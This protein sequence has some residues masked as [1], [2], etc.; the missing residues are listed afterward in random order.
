MK[1]G[2]ILEC[3]VLHRAEAG[4]LVRSGTLIGQISP[5]DIAWRPEHIPA[6]GD[7]VKVF[8]LFA[9]QRN[10]KVSFDFVGSIRDAYPETHPIHSLDDSIIGTRFISPVIPLGTWWW[11]LRHPS[12][13]PTLLPRVE[14]SREDLG[15][16]GE[17]EVEVAR[18]DRENK[19]LIA[20]F[21]GWR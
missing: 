21:A 6:E 15:D 2:D 8:V 12:G 9:T 16:A 18:I 14:L 7:R 4:F 3:I 11:G 19:R 1:R 13:V 5:W 20:H 10:E 17:I